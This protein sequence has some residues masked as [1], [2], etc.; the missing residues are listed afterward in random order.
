MTNMRETIAD[1][2]AAKFMVD[3]KRE[4]FRASLRAQLNAAESFHWDDLRVD[5]DPQGMLL[6][7]VRE[8][9][10]ECSGFMG[11]ARDILPMK[12]K[13]EVID[14]KVSVSEGYVPY[15]QIWP[16]EEPRDV[17]EQ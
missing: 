3:D 16:V 11:S 4:A 2:W 13:M 7:A 15:R 17:S 6:T 1:Y 9:G 12:H 8:A 10:I 14:G 5:Y